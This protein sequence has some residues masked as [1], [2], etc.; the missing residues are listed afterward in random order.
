MDLLLL[1]ELGILH[2]CQLGLCVRACVLYFLPNMNSIQ[3]GIRRK[4][5]PIS[6]FYSTANTSRNTVEFTIQGN[7]QHFSFLQLSE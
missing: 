1:S 4:P 5:V 3:I 6:T 2:A 7:D